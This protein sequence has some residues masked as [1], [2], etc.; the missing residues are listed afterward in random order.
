MRLRNQRPKTS[1]KSL[2]KKFTALK[3]RILN[4]TFNCIDFKE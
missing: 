1:S 3:R 4:V 2:E